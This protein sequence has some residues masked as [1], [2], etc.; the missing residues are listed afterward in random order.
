MLATDE[1]S[2]VFLLETFLDDSLISNADSI[3]LSDL[4]LGEHTILAS[5]TDNVG[6]ATTSTREF[7]V[8]AT[9][10]TTLSDLQFAYKQDWITLHGIYRSLDSQLK[11]L[12]RIHNRGHISIAKKLLGGIL[13]Q[14]ESYRDKF[15]TE[16]GFNLLKEDLE[17]LINN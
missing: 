11:A 10:D 3:D 16:E 9:F 13:R 5:S 17:W 15:V 6:N 1:E 8:V 2:G 4:A 14:V 12:E 7:R